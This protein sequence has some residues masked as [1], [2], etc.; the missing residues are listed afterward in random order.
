MYK[1]VRRFL[2]DEHIRDIYKIAHSE[3]PEWRPAG[4]VQPRNM[5]TR[6]RTRITD[7]KV[8]RPPEYFKDKLT[9]LFDND[10]HFYR[11]GGYAWVE[12]WAVLRYNGS[13][14]G[15]FA[16]HTDDL[17]FFLY[18]NDHMDDAGR[19]DAEKIFIHNA[20]PKRKISI[21]IQLN[22][23]SEFEG[24]DLFIQR[25]T[26]KAEFFENGKNLS[27]EHKHLRETADRIVLDK[28]DMVMFD[29]WM[30]HEVTPVQS[31]IRD[32][33]VIWVADKEEWDK[34]NLMMDV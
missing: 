10:D 6:N 28:G 17:D 22:D 16:W 5:Q 2:S 3:M 12:Q 4:V 31:G 14:K 32:A 30:G 18:N 19:P 26:E 33:L 1:V 27:R 13:V 8:F 20:R 9:T 11:P 34:F 24:G 21:S 15:R 29:S 7:Q 23:Q 25:N